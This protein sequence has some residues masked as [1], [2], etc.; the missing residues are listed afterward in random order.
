MKAIPIYSRPAIW[1]HWIVAALILVNVCLGL[2]ADAAPEDWVRPV[3]DA[4]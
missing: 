2:Y 4:H 1:L 3:I